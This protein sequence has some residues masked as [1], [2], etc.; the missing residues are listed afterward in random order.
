M[1]AGV[2]NSDS[3]PVLERMLQFSAQR[4]ELIAHNIA[5][6]DTPHFQP[7][8]VSVKEFQA[9]LADAVDQ[10]R[11]VH[12]NTGGDLKLKDTHE[13]TFT[14]DGL[15]LHPEARGENILFHDQNDRDVES[16]MQDLVE[17]FLTFRTTAQLIRSRFD[18]I[19]TAIRE[20]L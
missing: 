20:R 19:N 11:A 1:I 5:N 14:P 7:Q 8:D 15:E 17:N 2:T 3:V 12:G 4:H 6:F 13:V 9:Q 16:I 18:L 10:H